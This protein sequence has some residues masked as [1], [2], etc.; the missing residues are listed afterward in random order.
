[1]TS[2]NSTRLSIKWKTVPAEFRKGR[3]LGYRNGLQWVGED[4]E[5]LP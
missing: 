5:F 2:Q 1:M 4:T 3:C